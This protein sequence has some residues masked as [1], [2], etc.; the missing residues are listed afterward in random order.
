MKLLFCPV[1][2]DFMPEVLRF[3]LELS[4]ACGEDRRGDCSCQ[5]FVSVAI[6]ACRLPV[7]DTAD[8]L[9][10]LRAFCGTSATFVPQDLQIVGGGKINGRIVG[11]ICFGVVLGERE[12][13]NKN[14]GWTA[15][16]Q[17]PPLGCDKKYEKFQVSSFK[18]EGGDA[19]LTSCPTRRV[20]EPGLHMLDLAILSPRPGLGRACLPRSQR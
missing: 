19:A 14:E 3:W 9:S 1:P 6:A 15:I 17:P 12:G 8:K 11:G 18:F 16:V 7:G 5:K 2:F 4:K 13:G 10:A 20:G